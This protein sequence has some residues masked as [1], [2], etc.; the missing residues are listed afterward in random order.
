[1]NYTM[2]L[3][4]WAPLLTETPL[5][6]TQQ[7][8][9]GKTHKP[10]GRAEPPVPPAQ[11]VPPGQ[12][13]RLQGR[14]EQLVLPG[15]LERLGRQVPQDPLVPLDMSAQM[16]PPVPLDRPER[17]ARVV[18]TQQLQ[19]QPVRR[20]ILDPPDPLGRREILAPPVR[21]ERRATSAL[22]V[23]RALLEMPDQQVQLGR[24]ATPDLPDL[25]DLQGTLVRLDPRALLEMSVPLVRRAIP[26]RPDQL[27]LRV[28]LEIQVQ[29]EQL[30]TSGRLAPQAQQERL[31]RPG[32]L[33]RPAPLGQRG[34]PVQPVL[35]V[36]Q[37]FLPLVES[38]TSP[39]QTA[40]SLV[41]NLYNQTRLTATHKMT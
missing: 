34:Q 3:S 20:G 25:L 13:R 16:V 17:Q 23:Q 28:I 40:T 6:T 30:A 14:P 5:S 41:T 9:C 24:K 1:M 29:R 18:L 8:G 26:V 15:Q 27:A 11:P 21:R 12:H 2:L 4:I 37:V 38:G 31:E 36:P 10:L 7:Q 35:P 19:G 32:R 33:A 39:R 22:P